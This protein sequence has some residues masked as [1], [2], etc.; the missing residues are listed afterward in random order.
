MRKLGLLLV[1]F[2][3]A[4]A[5]AAHDFWVQPQVF[6]APVGAAVP[7]TVEVGHGSFRQRWS[8]AIDRVASF[9][10]VGPGGT[11]DRRADLHLDSGAS[12]AELRFAAPGT[13]LVVLTTNHASSNLPAIRFNDYAKTEGLV[14]ALAV[15]AKAGTA[16]T[17]GR[18][19]YSR[20]AKA[21]VEIGTTTA[22]QPWVTKPLG[23][24]LEIVPE[25]NPYALK[26]DEALPVRVYYDGRPLAGALVKLT[27]LD[28][29]AKPV[30]AATTDTGG[31]AV[32]GIPF[33]GLWQMNVIW[34][35]Q[36]AGTPQADFDTTFSSLTFGT[37]RPGKALEGR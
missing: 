30:R 18:E 15:R 19:I 1:G 13:Y 37:T 10:T 33:R 34:T 22:P 9:A 25:R 23:L 14:P 3:A 11:V 5:A 4:S 31:R 20:R 27:N 17:P 29:D 26:P 21:L 16:D 35:K 7:V 8:V 6:A 36:I 2:G 12:D 24:T 28:F 32:F